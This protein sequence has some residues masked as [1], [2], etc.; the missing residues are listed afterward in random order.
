MVHCCQACTLSGVVKSSQVMVP[1]REGAVAPFDIGAG[2][3]QHLCERFG[4]VLELVLRHRAQRTQGALPERSP[5]SYASFPR[6]WEARRRAPWG[7]DARLREPDVVLVPDLR[8][9]P[10]VCSACVSCGS[11]VCW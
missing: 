10:R 9:R 3:L 7:L 2:A 5:W 11:G 8:N 1:E 6:K 4:L